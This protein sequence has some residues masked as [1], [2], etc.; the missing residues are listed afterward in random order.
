MVI[1]I[2]IWQSFKMLFKIAYN[3]E[4]HVM[5]VKEVINF[6]KLTQFVN[7]V[8][9]KLP[10]RYS[11]VYKDTDGDIICLANDT[12]MKALAES[13]IQKIRIE[14]QP[15]N[16]EDFYDETQEIVLEEPA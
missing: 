11:L 13:G 7:S 15:V 12:D 16:N 1:I 14:I 8:F 3:N 5:T 10:E 2:N 4:I 9:K 6:S